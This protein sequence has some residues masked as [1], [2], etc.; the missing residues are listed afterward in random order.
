[1]DKQHVK[2]FNVDQK[3]KNRFR[4]S[5]AKQ[6]GKKVSADVYRSYKRRFGVTTAAD[7][8][9]NVHRPKRRKEKEEEAKD[10]NDDFSSTFAEELELANDRNG[11][12]LFSEFYREVWPLV[13]SVP[14]LLHHSSSVVDLLLSYMLSPESSPGEKSTLE[15][16]PGNLQSVFVPNHATTDVLHLL[17][18]LAKDMQHEIHGFVYS[19][20]LPRI[21]TDL[22][23]PP[24][25]SAESGKQA[26]PVDVLI[27][28]TAFRTLSYIF[29]H[30]AEKLVT[31]STKEGEEPC[32]EHIR[33]YYGPT[34]GHKRDVVRRL[35]AETFAPLI[36]R[37]KT[38][39]ARKKHLKRV[40]RALTK[41]DSGN[42]SQTLKRAKDDA[43]DGVATLLFEAAKGVS[44]H[45]HS[46][47]SMIIRSVLDY[48]VGLDQDISDSMS[49]L[50]STFLQKL[51]AHIRNGTDRKIDDVLDEIRRFVDRMLQKG[52]KSAGHQSDS[53][54]ACSIGLLLE[55]VQFRNGTFFHAGDDGVDVETERRLE[56]CLRIVDDLTNEENCGIMP[57]TSSAAALKLFFAIWNVTSKLDLSPPFFELRLSKLV[58]ES[59]TRKL[60][61]TV[62]FPTCVI[63]EAYLN[64]CTEAKAVRVAFPSIISSIAG[65]S[66]DHADEVK[67]LVFLVIS[68]LTLEADGEKKDDDLFP[69]A[70]KNSGVVCDR[71]ACLT[72]LEI[73][74][75]QTIDVTAVADPDRLA[76]LSY[77]TRSIPFLCSITDGLNT[78]DGEK[79]TLLWLVKNLEILMASSDFQTSSLERFVPAALLIETFA[80]VASLV[81]EQTEAPW[82]KRAL[83]RCRS[84]AWD[85]VLHSPRSLWATRALSSLCGL[86]RIYDM[87]LCDDANEA[88]DLLV[89][90]LGRESHF[91]RLYTLRILITFPT[92]P[93]VT[94]HKD[95]DLMDDLDEESSAAPPGER[96]QSGLSGNCD[97]IET[98]LKI[99]GSPV[100]V[101]TERAIAGLLTRV[102]VLGKSGRL[103]IAYAEALANHM[104]GMFH[105]KFSSWWP[106]A[107]RAL[108]GLSEGHH[109]ILCE[110]TSEVLERLLR[111]DLTDPQVEGLTIV[112]ID[113]CTHQKLCVVWDLSGGRDASLFQAQIDAASDEGRVSPFLSTD[114]E[115][116][117]LQVMKVLES[118]PEITAKYSRRIV[119]MFLDF[120][121][122]QYYCF[123]DRDPDSR[124]LQI[125]KW[126]EG[127]RYA[128]LC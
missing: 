71:H 33:K 107:S 57:V 95:L 123:H 20:I 26:I 1:M 8:E 16:S 9:E 113:A 79:R 75:S 7:R 27:A 30:D 105:V 84:I 51:Y 68:R 101:D 38:D 61:G 116:V 29:Q 55:F 104:I 120:L 89:S 59:P 12:A 39:A 6:R 119:P 70:S 78:H 10:E 103:P 2:S 34:L 18:V 43:I 14:E 88:F 114:S 52:H 96:N 56:S 72:L 126:P 40:L 98:L 54:L 67:R 112:D 111:P 122:A 109:T 15:E 125:D 32:L 80:S 66:L 121:K 99:E 62:T 65:L 74:M 115:T 17:A 49:V 106:G 11:S 85:M 19:K 64:A 41:A 93:Y 13:R 92:R 22:L 83:S 31:E 110:A 90:N 124:E 53:S 36:R 127:Q 35:A 44:G 73:F 94:N 87:S 82:L 76:D 21:V 86:L 128:S 25:P 3:G 63:V 47:G 118:V 100:G 45:L 37:M 48:I 102:E 42:P 46:K 4:F 69:M 77:S 117:F 5:S 91:L 28:E 97:I 24:P 58:K 81:P 23:N 60:E 50:A 108:S